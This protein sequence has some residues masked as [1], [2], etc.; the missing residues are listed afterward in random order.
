MSF[1]ERIGVVFAPGIGPH[2][3]R[4]T[5]MIQDDRCR[6]KGAGQ[7]DH[8]G[9]LCV[10]LPGLERQ[11][12]RRKLG[13]PLAKVGAPIESLRRIGMAVA[14]VL[15]G[16]PTCGMTNTPK[17]PIAGRNQRLQHRSGRC[18]A[19]QIGM[20]HDAGTRL[21]RA[22]NA[23]RRHRSH[24]VDKLGLTDRTHFGWS[25]SAI[26]GSAFDKHGRLNP[27]PRT[28]ISQQFIKQIAMVGSVPEMVM[29]IDDRQIGFDDRLGRLLREPCG[30]GRKCAADGGFVL[31][32]VH[33]RSP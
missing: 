4:A 3:E 19:Q 15:A 2:A 26:K 22:I 27:V 10:V 12:E 11:T 31:V 21:H 24:A 8:L 13:K 9:Q 17:A 25:C 33:G 30:V 28:G 23:A 29:R 7:I 18:T 20:T 16:I 5:D 32:F 1:P 14:D 6:R